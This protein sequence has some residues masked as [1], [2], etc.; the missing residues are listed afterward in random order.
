MSVSKNHANHI[1]NLKNSLEIEASIAVISE[2]NNNQWSRACL[3]VNKVDPTSMLS[4]NSPSDDSD[5][6]ES[7]RYSNDR[8]NKRKRQLP[9]HLAD[10]EVYVK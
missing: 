10:Y 7:S 6:A 4:S 8:Q 5:N 9:R 2:M 3:D 1:F